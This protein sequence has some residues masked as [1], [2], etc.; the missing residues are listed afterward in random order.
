MSRET[1]AVTQR[2]GKQA[3]SRRRSDDGEGR[4]CQRDRR[5]AGALTHDDVDAEV[6]HGEVQH[7]LG[8]AREAVDLVD[9]EDV[10]LLKARQNR[11]EVASVL[12]RGTRRQA[13]RRSH[14]GRDDHRKRRLTKS[15]RA[16]EEN[17]IGAGRTH[18][19]GVEHELQLAS[20]D[21]LADELREL[22]RA[23]RGLCGTLELPGIGGDD[24]HRI[25]VET[26][27]HLISHVRLPAS[28]GQHAACRRRQAHCPPASRWPWPPE[29]R[30]S[31]NRPVRR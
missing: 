29:P 28:R 11:G 19:R 6:L 23:Q 31:P 18:A 10:A 20:H 3:G 26:G 1:E 12:D 27:I 15:G 9:E 25:N 8:S 17:M 22:L 24:A 5:R 13:Q 30:T 2:C 14:L 7:F 16:C 21:A 4:E